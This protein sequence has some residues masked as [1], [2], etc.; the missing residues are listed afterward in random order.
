MPVPGREALDVGHVPGDQLRIGAQLEGQC[1]RPESLW[2]PV[3][4][5]L[6]E[7]LFEA[8]QAP[9]GRRLTDPQGLGSLAERPV[10]EPGEHHD[11]VFPCDVL[12]PLH[13]HL[14]R[15]RMDWMRNRCMAS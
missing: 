6:L 9:R 3:E 8:N 2:G 1:C 4:E 12:C 13:R 5:A 11:Q 10:L 15:F 14:I 7:A